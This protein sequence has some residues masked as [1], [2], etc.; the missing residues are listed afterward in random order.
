[1]FPSEILNIIFTYD[2]C[3]RAVTCR[4]NWHWY[5]ESCK[6]INTD[7]SEATRT[8]DCVSVLRSRD[9]SWT[10]T[11]NI[12]LYIFKN[13]CP[14]LQ[15]QFLKYGSRYY[16]LRALAYA[17]KLDIIDTH[18]I[19]SDLEYLICYAC[20]GGQAKT[21]E[22]LML[23]ASEF[24]FDVVYNVAC[25]CGIYPVANHILQLNPR[26]EYQTGLVLA[27]LCGH[28][29]LV[30]MLAYVV[31]ATCWYYIGACGHS[32]IVNL[33]LK[34]ADTNDLE[35]CL[36]GAYYYGRVDDFHKILRLMPGPV[37]RNRPLTEP[38]IL[39][40]IATSTRISGISSIPVNQGGYEQ[41]TKRYL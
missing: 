26:I 6:Y 27:C 25:V 31:T 40:A 37:I 13:G 34:Y 12:H 23:R 1:M 39:D 9:N 8:G 28:F 30:E 35:H 5:H 41:L 3:T 36:T 29:E 33:M 20:Y 15:N 22:Y 10:Y 38:E 17:G 2:S 4:L 32:N 16:I 11:N 14:T 19:E 24:R 18:I 21:A 7:L